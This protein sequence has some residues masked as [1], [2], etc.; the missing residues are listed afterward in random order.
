M[1]YKYITRSETYLVRSEVSPGQFQAGL[2]AYLEAVKAEDGSDETLTRLDEAQD[3]FS[4]LQAEMPGGIKV[5]YV[6]DDIDQNWQVPWRVEPQVALD[7]VN[8]WVKAHQSKIQ[9]CEDEVEHWSVEDQE[10]ALDWLCFAEA[11]L[12]RLDIKLVTD[13]GDLV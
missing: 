5:Y 11:E 1:S 6:D 9:R 10:V 13:S 3:A 8:R 12:D 7:A 2:Q 4:D